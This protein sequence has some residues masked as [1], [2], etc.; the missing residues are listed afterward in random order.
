M[1]VENVYEGNGQGGAFEKT[2]GLLKLGTSKNKGKIVLTFDANSKF[3]TV[4]ITCHAWNIGDSS[5][6]SVNGVEI[7][8]PN[9]GVASEITF[10][11]TESN[12]IT[13]EPSARA[14]I[15]AISLD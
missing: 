15:F 14:F 1:V 9:T 7:E 10:S 11:I 4:T 6:M 2:S 5:K 13:I 12:V 8:M 3:S